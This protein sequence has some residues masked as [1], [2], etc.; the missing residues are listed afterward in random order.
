MFINERLHF[1]HA[2]LKGKHLRRLLHLQ[3]AQLLNQRGIGEQLT[4]QRSTVLTQRP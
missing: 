2:R 3:I 4:Q 1:L